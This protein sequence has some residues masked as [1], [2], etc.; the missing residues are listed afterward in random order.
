MAGVS[1]K[2]LIAIGPWPAGVDNLSEENSLTRSDDGKRIIALRESVNADIPRDGWPRRREGRT[3]LIELTRGHSGWARRGFP[4]L[5][6]ADGSTLFGWKPGQEPFAIVTGI[7]PREISYAHI[8]DRVYCTNNRQTWVV[9]ATGESAAWGV[10]TPVGRP[11]LT[12]STDGGLDPGTY[13][14][15]ITF[16]NAAGEES[17]AVRAAPITLPDGGG[18]LCTSIPQPV[19]V[20][21]ARVRIYRSPA[22]GDVLY[23]V[24]DLPVGQTQASLQGGDLRK[25]LETLFLDPMPPAEIVRFLGA[26]LWTASGN[27]QRWSD[28]TRYGLTDLERNVRHIG[29][30]IVMMEA[31][32]DGGE[33]PG[34]YV[35]D[36]RAVYWQDGVDPN[37]QRLKIAVNSPA[38]RGSSVMIQASYFKIDSTV[39]VAYW[40]CQNGVAYLGL[41]GGTVVPLTERQAIAPTADRGASLFIERN[42]LRRMLTTLAGTGKQSLAVTDRVVDRMYRDGIEI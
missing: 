12:A 4:F 24:R 25:Q 13:Q 1:D 37:A 33:A 18:I 8:A 40:L 11:T 41:P 9:L 42:G 15:A 7:A 36:T 29:R 26:R 23:M 28:P 38:I 17:G 31:V 14:V 6:F 19:G 39:P 2:E 32:G 35:S 20:D 30:A 22:N 16:L 21:V 34:M 5:M 3:K 10:E 27:T